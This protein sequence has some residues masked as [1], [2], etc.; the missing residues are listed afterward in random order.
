MKT[1]PVRRVEMVQTHLAS[2]SQKNTMGPDVFN[3]T[4]SDEI[5]ISDG[6]GS[7]FMLAVQKTEIDMAAA[8]MKHMT[9]Q[10]G[11]RKFSVSEHLY[12]IRVHITLLQRAT[13]AWE[14]WTR[15]I[16]PLR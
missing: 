2:S 12:L 16:L 8:V 5:R 7:T 3:F 9:I 6:A 13:L 14:Q 15:Q 4:G 10:A 11:E 1:R